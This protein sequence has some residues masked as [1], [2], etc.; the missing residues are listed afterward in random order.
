MKL[1]EIPQEPTPPGKRRVYKN[2]YGNW[3]GYVG[4]QRWKE[5]GCQPWSEADANDWLSEG[6]S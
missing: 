4:A 6:A 2:I 5:F 3:V 1:P